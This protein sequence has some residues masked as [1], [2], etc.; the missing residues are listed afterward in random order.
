[1]SKP[2]GVSTKSNAFKARVIGM[3]AT[4]VSNRKI[5]QTT[6]ADE[7]TIAKILNE[8]D[9][10]KLLEH[11][12]YKLRKLTDDALDV[13]SRRMNKKNDMEAATRIL[14]DTGILIP[15]APVQGVSGNPIGIFSQNN[16]TSHHTS[17]EENEWMAPLFRQ[18]KTLEGTFRIP[19]NGNGHSKVEVEATSDVGE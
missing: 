19:T 14:E 16:V 1:M 10:L 12:R 17:L 8:P 3:S 9:S 2:K 13:Y 5:S 6:K 15:R 11:S 4:G 7:H 18:A